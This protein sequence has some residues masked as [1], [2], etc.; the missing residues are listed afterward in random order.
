[1][2]IFIIAFLVIALIGQSYTYSN[3]EEILKVE[4]ELKE[5]HRITKQI[6][7]ISSEILFSFK[8]DEDYEKIR[9]RIFDEIEIILVKYFEKKETD[10]KQIAV[11]IRET[12]VMNMF[13]QIVE[14]SKKLSHQGFGK[15]NF[16][17]NCH[18]VI[19]DDLILLLEYEGFKII[20]QDES[21][22]LYSWVD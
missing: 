16:T 1:M 19:K 6:Y 17:D 8:N 2:K 14:N 9:L 20:E 7:S 21:S 10:S 11:Y 3:E 15:Y 18:K 5:I 22:I 12:V 4:N 13:L